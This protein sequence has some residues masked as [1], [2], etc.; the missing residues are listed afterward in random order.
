[1]SRILIDHVAIAVHDLRARTALLQT[2]FG[3]KLAHEETVEDQAV[4]TAIFGEGGGRIELIT[5]TREDTGVAK[6]LQ[7]RGEGLH[8]ICLQVDDIDETLA[9]LKAQGVPL[10]D[11][12]P[13]LG[14]Q[15]ARIAFVHP[16]GAMGVLVEL[17]EPPRP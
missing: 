13:R 5:P 7:K 6:F 4:H 2:A 3:L 9:S 12:Q 14:A 16:K 8:H 15:G 1:M 17:R 11:E 10:I